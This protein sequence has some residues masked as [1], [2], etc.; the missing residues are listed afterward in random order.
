LVLRYWNLQFCNCIPI[1][2]FWN[3][4]LCYRVLVSCFWNLLFP[5]VFWCFATESCFFVNALL[6]FVIWF[7]HSDIFPLQHYNLH[8]CHFVLT[9]CYWKLLFCYCFVTFCHWNIMTRTFVIVFFYF[10]GVN[11]ILVIWQ[12]NMQFGMALSD[13]FLDT[14]IYFPPKCKYFNL[15]KNLTICLVERYSLILFYFFFLILS[16]LLV[17]NYNVIKEEEKDQ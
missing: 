2:C 15:C 7:L 6:H 8:F 5:V 9:S 1:S 10:D 12:G 16:T 3:L 4:L 13:A 17:I 14:I 11:F